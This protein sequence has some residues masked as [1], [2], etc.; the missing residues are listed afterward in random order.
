MSTGRFADLVWMNDRITTRVCEV[1]YGNAIFQPK[2][3]N[4]TVLLS[5]GHVGDNVTD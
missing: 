5:N 4:G 1:G 3:Q 2:T